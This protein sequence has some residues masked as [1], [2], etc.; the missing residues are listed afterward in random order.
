MELALLPSRLDTD[1]RVQELRDPATRDEAQARLHLLLLRAAHF[2][3]GRREVD[4][5]ER[6]DM[7]TQA[8]DDALMAIIGKL[9]T[10][11]GE[12]RFTTWAYKFA[13]LEAGVRARRR[14]W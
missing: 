10:F 14:A 7:A 9:D 5:G 11:R 2:E 6:A 8:A 4:A 3:L 12:S 1:T 13:L